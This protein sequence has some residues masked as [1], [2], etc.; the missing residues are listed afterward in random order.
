MARER[1]RIVKESKGEESHENMRGGQFAVA[2]QALSES[3]GE[4]GG[5]VC[6]ACTRR[7]QKH[8]ED[9]RVTM[10][11]FPCLKNKSRS[12]PETRFALPTQRLLI[13]LIEGTD[14]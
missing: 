9:V 7:W 12:L 14:E 6:C 1:E 10:V 5:V 2:A 11:C 3:R 13:T 4:G 8:E